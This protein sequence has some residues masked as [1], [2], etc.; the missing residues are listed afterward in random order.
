[1]PNCEHCGVEHPLEE[2]ELSFRRPDAV[3]SVPKDERS[4]RVQKNN[5]LCVLDGQR[6]FVRALL[7]LK[8]S[9]RASA[10]NMGVWVEIARSSYERVCELW[11]EPDQSSEPSFLVSLANQIP[12][13]PQTIGL[14]AQLAL[15][16]PST[17]PEVA[18][19]PAGH[20]LVLEQ[21]Q[22]IT[23]HRAHEYSSLFA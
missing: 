8:V 18:L 10:Y 12:T 21:V 13:H 1:M 6:F 20:P 17:R 5:D 15:T 4:E 14:Q 9:G 11:D 23:P 7:P 16:G 19:H 3:A 22:G 2:L